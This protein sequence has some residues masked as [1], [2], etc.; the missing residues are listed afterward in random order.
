MA[1]AKYQDVIAQSHEAI[2][3]KIIA[4]ATVAPKSGIYRC[5][6]CGATIVAEAGQQLPPQA[7]HRHHPAQ[8]GQIVW[9]LLVRSTH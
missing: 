5:L 3:D 9:Q 7:H 8:G 6:N 4:P 1:E 2:F